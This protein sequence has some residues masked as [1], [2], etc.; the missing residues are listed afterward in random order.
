MPNS[1]HLRE[2]TF[3]GSTFNTTPIATSTITSGGQPGGF[4][5]ISD[6]NSA[7]GSGIVWATTAPSAAYSGMLPGTLHAWNADNIGGAELWDSG[8]D[9]GRDNMGFFAK[10]PNP[11]IANG[12][13]YVGS[14]SNLVTV[15]GLLPV[16]AGAIL[17][18]GTD[19]GNPNN[20]DV[21]ISLNWVTNGSSTTY[22]QGD[23]VIFNDSAPGKTNIYLTTVLTPGS[24]TVSNSVLVYNLGAQ[25]QGG[26]GRISGTTGLTKQ[27]TNVLIL[28][29]TNS[30]GN[31]NDF[32][33]GLTISAGTVQVGNGDH[34]GSPG[35]GAISDN[36]ALVY[37]RV[38]NTTNASVIS[39]TG[40]LTQEGTGVLTVSGGNGYTGPT[41]IENGTLQVNNNSAFGPTN[42]G[43]VTITNGGT[44]DI[45]G[46]NYV[47]QGFILGLKQIYV[48]GWG[49]S[50]NGA[51]INSS[52]TYYQYA[53]DNIV[54]VTMQ[55]DTAIGGAGTG[56]PGNGNTGGRWDFRGQSGEPG[57]LSTG[58]HPYNLFK[59][60][61][62]Q[63]VFDDVGLDTNLANIDIRK[64]FFEVQ[65][66]TGLGNPGSNLTVEV[67]ATF[68]MY[69][70]GTSLNKNF[71]LN[72]NGQN[73]TVF[74]E[75]STNAL[76]GP[77]TLNGSCVFG[78]A[79]KENLSL[80]NVVG[81]PGNLIVSNSPGTNTLF[82][83]GG[84]NT[85]TGNTM[86]QSGTL[87]LTGNSTISDTPLISVNTSATL[88][89]S[90]RT[91]A[92]LTLA[93]GQTLTGNG[94]V[95]GNIIAGSGSIFEPGITNGTMIL[96]N[97]LTLNSGSTTIIQISKSL[98]PSNSMAQVIGNV[99]YGGTLTITN[100][101]TNSFA[102]GDSFKIFSA[103]GYSGA[104]T[105]VVPTIPGINLAWN[106]NTLSSGVLSV[107]AS[108]TPS[109]KIVTTLMSGGN[110]VFSGTNGVAGWPYYVL[111][112]TN[113]TLPTTN[114]S[115]IYTGA[116]NSSG[117][118]IFTNLAATNTQLF[119]L[120]E[121]P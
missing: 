21:G 91:G 1:D 15:Y 87:S 85:Y 16:P 24:V 81:G 3:N 103:A 62:N 10:D 59:V 31:Y 38:D 26:G 9:S 70:G 40:S 2:F 61:G 55:G 36:G 45:A 34:D 110:F 48:S 102:A 53:N 32:S 69:Q 104:F 19:P 114:W 89:A 17:W 13:V 30:S 96:S 12:K 49:V 105:G 116:F 77:V 41:L 107:V 35:I 99:V 68:G 78:C 72:G 113:I 71:L 57:V 86:V 42:A 63:I 46:P 52:P 118:F 18:T 119:Y 93:S 90:Q 7:P 94:M 111:T 66:T 65:G 33:G 6:N 121:L 79:N 108:P 60:G 112:T 29:E 27:G 37:D 95:K 97:N 54:L 50:S 22:T 88:D 84:N 5:S 75:G 58:G 8:M 109:P 11:T 25:G 64:G 115:L 83:S 20:W 100:L 101:A 14:Y 47:S 82:L 117:N 67:G 80:L 98:S 4:L 23:P 106:T 56:T 28:D 76:L 44:M 74:S 120:L 39:G 73:D 51:I 43:A 92:T